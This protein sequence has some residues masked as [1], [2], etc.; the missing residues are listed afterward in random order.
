MP[1]NDN[2]FKTIVQY[3]PQEFV[4]K[5]LPGAVYVGMLPTE[6]SR[7]PLRAD[8]LLR[9][10]YPADN[11]EEY[12]LHLEV[13]T[14]AD[15][16][17][18][19][20]LCTYSVLASARDRLP[21]HSVVIYLEPCATPVSPWRQIGPNGPI[22]EY[23]FH[24]MRLWEESLDD[25]LAAGFAGMMIFAPLLKGASINRMEEIAEAVGH[26]PDP[27]QR[28]NSLHYLVHFADRA[29]GQQAVLD[30]LRGHPMF[31]QII[32]ESGFY[33]EILQRGEIETRRS[34]I[35]A[36]VADRFPYLENDAQEYLQK[37]ADTATLREALLNIAR[38]S[39]EISART[40][41]G[42]PQP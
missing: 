2:A 15:P 28:K 29:F 42:L 9:V 6:L 35:L 20:R 7:E 25:W 19:R 11:G 18:P 14:G 26:I 30:Y 24:V 33:K 27:E 17:M 3:Q 37:I 13:Q 16:E 23:H 39:D 22:L 4:S 38:A 34:D 8:A 10:R 21:V 41:L 31:D 36:I 1:A 40:A 32:A 5:F 12:A